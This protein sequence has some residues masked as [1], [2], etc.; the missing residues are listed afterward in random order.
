MK[1]LYSLLLLTFFLVSCSTSKKIISK[2]ESKSE[3]SQDTIKIANYDLEY[4]IIIIETG[5]DFW[6]ASRA[7]PKS[8]YTKSFLEGKNRIYVT[9]WNSRVLSSSYNSNLYETSINYQPDID[10]GFDVNY[11]LYHYFVFFQEK[12]NQQLSS[13]NPRF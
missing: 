8:F 5:F 4:E 3:K 1:T 10:Y 7:K 13:H 6:M 12:Y 11:L 2:T 9:E